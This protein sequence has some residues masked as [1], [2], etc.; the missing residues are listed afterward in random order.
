MARAVGGQ[1]VTGGEHTLEHGPE[2]LLLGWI[3]GLSPASAH[4]SGARRRPDAPVC[5][6]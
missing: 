6:P 5:T 2:R 1:E 3:A 4:Q